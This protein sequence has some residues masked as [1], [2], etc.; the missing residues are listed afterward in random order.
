MSPFKSP[1]L[2]QNYH[3][4]YVERSSGKTHMYVKSMMSL[5]VCKMK[6]YCSRKNRCQIN[7]FLKCVWKISTLSKSRCLIYKIRNLLTSGFEIIVCHMGW[8]FSKQAVTDPGCEQW[9]HT[10]YCIPN[11]SKRSGDPFG[12]TFVYK[13]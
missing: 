10:S 4:K 8:M 6:V 1:Y 9:V 12:Y 5:D 3:S 2:T 11:N 13:G 7:R